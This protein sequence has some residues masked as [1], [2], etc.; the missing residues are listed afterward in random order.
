MKSPRYTQGGNRQQTEA[1]KRRERERE[2]AYRNTAQENGA[3]EA[4]LIQ[5]AVLYCL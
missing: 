2:W 1:A 4:P 3:Q 5:G